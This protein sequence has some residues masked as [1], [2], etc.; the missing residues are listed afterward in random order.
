M[1]QEK[2]HIQLPVVHLNGTGRRTLIE[3][4]ENASS[5]V[6]SAI[7][8]VA[9]IEFN[10]RDYYVAEPGAWEVARDQRTAILL[11]LREVQ[12]YLDAHLVH[13]SK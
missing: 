8:S 9:N 1:S 6:L 13:L 11:K 10:A 4:Y 5:A 2:I 3:D 12:H 7:D